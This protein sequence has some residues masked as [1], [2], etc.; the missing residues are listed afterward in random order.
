MSGYSL[1]WQ[2]G[3][4]IVYSPKPLLFASRDAC[5]ASTPLVSEGYHS[6][7]IANSVDSLLGHFLKGM[8][9][10]KCQCRQDTDAR[11]PCGQSVCSELRQHAGT[12]NTGLIGQAV[13][14]VQGRTVVAGQAKLLGRSPILR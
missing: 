2:V 3:F 8:S 6:A 7:S 10:P 11:K 12:G 13:P 9:S 4:A 14:M 1:G 5:L